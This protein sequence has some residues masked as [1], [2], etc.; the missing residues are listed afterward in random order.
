[1]A[2]PGQT[3]HYNTVH[4]Y[5]ESWITSVGT[6]D[7]S[8]RQAVANLHLRE[9]LSQQAEQ[10][11][12]LE[13]IRS[14][15]LTTLAGDD[16]PE[17]I[18][19][20]CGRAL[21]P[22]P[23]DVQVRLDRRVGSI[24]VASVCVHPAFVETAKKSIGP[25]Q[26]KV[27]STAG[28]F[29][30]GQ[31]PVELKTAEIRAALDSGADEIDAVI[32]RTYPLLGD[33]NALF[34]EVS[35]FRESCGSA[36]L[37]VI[38]ATGELGSAS[39]IEATSRTCLLAGADFIKTSTGKEAVNATL[40]AGHAMIAAIREHER[41]T[42]HRAGLKPAG[43]LATTSQVLD[44]AAMVDRELGCGY[45]SRER[46]RIGASSLLDALVSRLE[47]LSADR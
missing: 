39:C 31:I 20:L 32:R 30:A 11:V 1:M 14:L 21:D 5:D 8:A 13:C 36:T 2:S 17:H 6:T 4:S 16:T 28:G 9:P 46:F 33:W 38:L 22:L 47:E 41:L 12:L 18:R 15:D 26:V 35:A 40:E 19:R 25:G 24:T 42:G 10:E 43:G 37:K 27:C 34:D 45:R 29:P 3:D 7:A 23:D 44:W